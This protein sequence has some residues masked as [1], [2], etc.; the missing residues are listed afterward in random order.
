M[1]VL[2]WGCRSAVVG[3]EEREV[4]RVGNSERNEDRSDGG[5]DLGGSGGREERR[6]TGLARG[7][8]LGMRS[9]WIHFLITREWCLVSETIKVS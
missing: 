2:R 9:C 6:R 4:A 5:F 7:E 3:S 1:W 8:G